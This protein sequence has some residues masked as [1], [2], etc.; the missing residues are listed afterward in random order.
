M[1]KTFQTISLRSKILYIFSTM[2]SVAMIGSTL[3]LW[4]TYQMDNL[5]VN[6]VEK[7]IVLYKAVKEMELALSNQKG[8]VTYYLVDGD[9]KWL[10]Y[11]G[12]YRALFDQ[13]YNQAVS[14]DLNDIQHS[15]LAEITS[16][17]KRYILAKDLAIENYK[18][19]KSKE[20]DSSYN[21]ISISS[22]HSAQRTVFFNLLD[23]CKN[24]NKDLWNQIKENEQKHYER[25]EKLR[26]MV[27]SAIVFFMFLGALFLF[28]LYMKVLQPIRGL[29]IKTGGSPME[30]SRNEVVSLSHSLKEM[31]K[32]YGDTHNELKRSRKHLV[33]AERMAMVGELAAGVAHSIRNPFTSIKM[34]LFS[35]NR[36]LDLSDVQN[37]DL[38]VIE[39]EISRIDK[40]VQNF[41]DFAR[42]PKLSIKTSTFESVVKSVIT[43]VEYRLKQQ[44]VEISY[45]AM[46]GLPPVAMDSDRIREALLNLITNASEAIES[47]ENGNRR[48]IVI[49]ENMEH[50]PEIGGEILCL[51]VR[52]NG[53]GIPEHILEKILKPFF[54]TKEDG[55]GLGLS[56]VD[57]I[58]REHGGT[59]A[60]FSEGEGKGAE[61][62]LKLPVKRV[63]DEENS[64][65]SCLSG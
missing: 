43:L 47:G 38:D 3:T 49:S 62:I 30:S 13:S 12:Q 57:R 53:P 9:A 1:I 14:L 26:M 33:Q 52:D 56:I 58:M 15:V 55:S 24:F 22:M 35:L 10:E 21:S 16:E 20:A 34:R 36:S 17:Y 32:D 6:I 48:L 5:L 11:L 7:N 50:D 29:A 4:Y 51:S 28:I 31:I 8:F 19:Q 23:M 45:V 65:Q 18:I 61:F 41:L 44:N 46:P 42:I 60:V 63:W 25:S 2:V 64:G 59:L 39:D 54:T 40:I 27:F 37:E